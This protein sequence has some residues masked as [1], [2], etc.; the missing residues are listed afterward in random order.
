MSER[1][2]TTKI[3]Y[4]ILELVSFG[5]HRDN[6]GIWDQIQLTILDLRV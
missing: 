3:R 2:Y 5:R 4:S 6:A 1:A